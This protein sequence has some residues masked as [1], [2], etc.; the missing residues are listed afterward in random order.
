MAR[1]AVSIFSPDLAPLVVEIRFGLLF[2]DF[3]AFVF[4]MRVPFL[5]LARVII[6]AMGVVVPGE[7]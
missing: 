4:L 2:R 1:E 7:G 6:P 5:T 3:E